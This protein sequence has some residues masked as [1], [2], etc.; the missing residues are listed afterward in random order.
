MSLTSQVGAGYS[1]LRLLLSAELISRSTSSDVTV[2]HCSSVGVSRNG[3]LAN[4][5]VE[6]VDAELQN[7]EVKIFTTEVILL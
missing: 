5:G 2:D 7:N 3:I 6:A 4:T 1:Q